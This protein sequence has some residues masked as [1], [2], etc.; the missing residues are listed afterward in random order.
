[1]HGAMIKMRLLKFL[2]DIYTKNCIPNE[3]RNA[4]V[5]PI[6]KKGDKDRPKKLQRN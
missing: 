6:F 1:M 2:N 5:I 3:G 4:S